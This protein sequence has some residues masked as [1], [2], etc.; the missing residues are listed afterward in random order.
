MKKM[1]LRDT[2]PTPQFKGIFFN[3]ASSGAFEFINNDNKKS[4]NVDYYDIY[5]REKLASQYFINNID[6]DFIIVDSGDLVLTS[7]ND[8]AVVDTTY[9]ELY[10]MLSGIIIERYKDKWNRIYAVLVEEE[11][12]ALENYNM[13]QRM[14]RELNDDRTIDLE[15]RRTLN[16]SDAN[17]RNQQDK[18]TYASSSAET[19]NLSNARTVNLTDQETKNLSTERDTATDT[20][21]TTTEKVNRFGYND[22]SSTGSPYESK[23]NNVSGS[24]TNNKIHEEIS[25]TGT[26]TTIHSG[27]DTTLETGTDTVAHTGDDTVARTGTDTTLH[28]GTDNN[29]HDG[30]D[31]VEHTGWETLERSGNIGVTTSQQMLESEIKLRASYN[32]ITIIYD[33]ID[34]VLTSPIYI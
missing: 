9:D 7:N 13:K 11:Y 17:T 32:M 22:N 26:D 5:S 30:T 27:T 21:I 10:N 18:T 25:E 6:Q 23:N 14:E 31:N 4:L 15:D 19:K 29:V 8:Y 16:L 1:K 2:I 28:T 34:K 24:G 20:D 33:D 12:N 3:L